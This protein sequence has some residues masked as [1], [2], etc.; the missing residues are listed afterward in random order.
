MIRRNYAV[1]RWL[2]WNTVPSTRVHFYILLD[3]G[4]LLARAWNLSESL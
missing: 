1:Y 4:L 3:Q 2:A